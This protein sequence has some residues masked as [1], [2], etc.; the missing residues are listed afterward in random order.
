VWLYNSPSDAH[1]LGFVNP[2]VTS[3]GRLSTA[4]A[5]PSN[6]N[7]FKQLI[8]T[9]ETQASPKQPGSVILQGVLTGV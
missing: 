2:G 5:L 4:G 1:L 3:N 8:V 7:H 9:R 6:A